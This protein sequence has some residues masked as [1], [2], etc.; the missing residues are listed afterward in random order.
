M[1]TNN[2]LKN[3]DNY[4]II[5]IFE[6]YVKN[7]TYFESFESKGFEPLYTDSE[8]IPLEEDDLK[9]LTVE[10][11]N[12]SHQFLVNIDILENGN[13]KNESFFKSH[14]KNQIYFEQLNGEY[15]GIIEEYNPD[16]Q[17]IKLKLV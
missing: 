17:E 15:T 4:L 11:L 16:T 8:F 13:W 7:E 9:K 1:K 5:K 10:L 14:F 6:V 3:I 12:L 2:N